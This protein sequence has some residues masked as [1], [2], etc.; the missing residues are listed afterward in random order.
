M[1][2]ICMMLLVP[3]CCPIKEP[4]QAFVGR[5][6]QLPFSAI[7]GKHYRNKNDLEATYIYYVGIHNFLLR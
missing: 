7:D 1:W 6:N 2:S 4:F 3:I 5:T